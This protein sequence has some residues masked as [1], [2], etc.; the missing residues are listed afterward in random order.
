VGLVLV[1]RRQ[2]GKEMRRAEDDR[3]A[4]DGLE[5]TSLN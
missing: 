4:Q 1:R 3:A 2:R 5:E